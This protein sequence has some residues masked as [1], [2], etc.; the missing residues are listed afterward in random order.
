MP[1][2]GQHIAFADSYASLLLM[3]N[4]P[5]DQKVNLTNYFI[6]YGIDLHGCVQ[7]GYGWPALGGHRSGR[8]LP[9]ILAGI[10]LGDEGMKN[11]SAS[12]PNKFGEDMQTLYINQLPPAGSFQQAWQGA[13]V[14][15]GGHYGVLTDG[16]PVTGGLYG[17]Y[18]QLQPSA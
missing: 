2:Y 6:Q 1:S 18:E 8:K 16:T 10:L 9:I 4:F 12:F 5:A 11:V 17:P 7:A 15:Y 14:I 3:L 13:T